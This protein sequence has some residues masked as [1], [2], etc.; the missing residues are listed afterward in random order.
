[1]IELALLAGLGAVG[2]L[3]ATDQSPKKDTTQ[4]VEQFTDTRAPRPTEEYPDGVVHSQNV[5]GHNNE[6]PFFGARVTQSMHSGATD[7]LLDHHTGA[8]K[9]YFQKRE[10]LSFFDSKPGTGN[11]FGG[12]VETEFMQSRMVSGQNMKNVFPIEQVQVGPG[13]NDGYTN[14]PKGGFQQ[15][16]MREFQL[17]PTT[18]ELRVVT[19]PKLSYE[20]PMIQGANAITM[21]GIQA[22]VKKNRPDK[23]VLLGMDRVNTAVGAQTAP[24]IYPE[25]PM[26][27]QARETTEGEYFGSVGG[28]I[29][30]LAPYVRAFTEPYQEFMKLTAEGRPNPAG[31]LGTGVAMGPEHIS[32]TSH[33]NE[34]AIIDA[35]RINA[36]GNVVASPGHAEHLGSYRFNQ[37]LQEDIHTQRN[38]PSIL[39][40]F[41]EN[42]YA[43]PLNAF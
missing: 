10:V 30:I 8:G 42:P 31:V 6:V 25:Q 9:E 39:K 7:S 4:L 11:P 35:G 2:Y 27:S 28:A 13:A 41:N 26:K 21:P 24:A 20:P 5:Q 22:E 36:G 16:Q 15:E 37:P 17:P 18:D 3:L 32:A 40:A 19:K 1:M 33:R 23:F 34:Q 14:I 38:H 29:A 12:Q 43:Q